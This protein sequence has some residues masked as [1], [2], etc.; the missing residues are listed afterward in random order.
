MYYTDIYEEIHTD[1]DPYAVAAGRDPPSGGGGS[2]VRSRAV[3]LAG[4]AVPN[5][6]EHVFVEEITC[7]FHKECQNKRMIFVNKSIFKIWKWKFYIYRKL[8]DTCY[9]FW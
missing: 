2:D 5:V 4:A 3:I 7:R 1:G 9:G 6:D 8:L